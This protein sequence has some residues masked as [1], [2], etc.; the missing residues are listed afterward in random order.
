MNT[1]FLLNE[2]VDYFQFVLQKSPG[3]LREETLYQEVTNPK[4][5]FCFAAFQKKF[6][7]L[8]LFY[9]SKAQSNMHFN[10]EPSRELIKLLDKFKDF[11]FGF[12]DKIG[13]AHV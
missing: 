1:N 7:E 13:R 12:K 4:L 2:L 10:A 8:L 5:K 9:N 6:N 11:K 3:E